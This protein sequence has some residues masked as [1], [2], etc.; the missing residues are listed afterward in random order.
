M[1]MCFRQNAATG[2]VGVHLWTFALAID[3]RG[4]GTV[5]EDEVLG[6]SGKPEGCP[7]GL[8]FRPLRGLGKPQLSFVMPNV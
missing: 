3:G 7:S 6:V 4:E 2:G 8:A 5:R 1:L